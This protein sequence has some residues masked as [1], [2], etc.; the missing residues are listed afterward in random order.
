MLFY[1][2]GNLGQNMHSVLNV[3]KLLSVHFWSAKH[4]EKLSLA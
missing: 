3:A 4:R 2:M 1:Y